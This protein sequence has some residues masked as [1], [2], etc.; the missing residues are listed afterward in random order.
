MIHLSKRLQAIADFVDTGDRVADIGTDHA[1]LPIALVQSGKCDYVLAS[2]IGAGPLAIAK[3]NI[4]DHGLSD[5]IEVRQG[6]GL[7][8]IKAS[9]DLDTVVIAGMGGELI[10]KIMN[11]GQHHLDGSENLILS[12]HRDVDQ[13][14]QWLADNEFGILDEAILTDE[15]H[16]YEII[17]A[18][19]TK[20]EVPYTAADIAFGPILRKQRSDLFVSELKRRQRSLQHVLA[21][22]K[23]ASGDIASKQQ[24]VQA[25]LDLVEAEIH[26][27]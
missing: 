13:V 27:D 15:G 17:V 26:A 19:R 10:C 14:R 2:D 24:Q 18:G 4:A 16:S 23:A 9:D 22:L 7:E 12:P 5:K 8:G 20:P 21:G 11:N 6:D 25:E 3:Q 1:F